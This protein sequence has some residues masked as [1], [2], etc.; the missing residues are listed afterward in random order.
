VIGT[1]AAR[2]IM[3]IS[4]GIVTG[5]VT[6][7]ERQAG[8]IRYSYFPLTGSTTPRRF[9]CQP[10]HEVDSEVA[11][12][13]RA[14]PGLTLSQRAAIQSTVEAWLR[15]AFTSRTPGLPGYLQLADATPGQIARGAE[16]DN[17]MGLYYGLYSPTRESN[18]AHRVAQ[19]LR[20]GLE[21]GIFH[22]T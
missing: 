1:V 10:D 19:Y 9:R 21:A 11:D 7:T 3:M 4:D 2:R 17:E 13:L 12:A 14:N 18:L 16:H 8:C 6:A 22:A 5:T 15:P 20:I